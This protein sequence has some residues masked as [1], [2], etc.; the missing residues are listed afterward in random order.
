MLM[1][2]TLRILIKSSN[3]YFHAGIK[4]L[5]FD[6]YRSQNATL[7]FVNNCT[8]RQTLD[9]VFHA[10]SYGS[11]DCICHY[12][13][14]NTQPPVLFVIRDARDYLPPPAL[15]CTRKTG[16][17][18]RDQP[19][20]E[21]LTMITNAMRNRRHIPAKP[22]PR[23]GPCSNTPLTA[24]E[25]EVLRYL[26]QGNSQVQTAEQM[27]LRVKTVNSHKR[28]AMKKLNFTRNNELLNWMLHGGL[29]SR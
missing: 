22:P 15:R 16:T 23:C 21:V 7:D 17:I 14:S 8:T 2:P 11:I 13:H 25:C 1:K 20:H 24:R 18:Y 12:F 3:T 27:Q 29:S 5:I 10:V 19:V 26:Q 6:V 4:S 9:L 28:S